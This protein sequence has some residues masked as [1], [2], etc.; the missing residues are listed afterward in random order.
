MIT[1]KIITVEEAEDMFGLGSELIED[2]SEIGKY[3]DAYI[4]TYADGD[5][6]TYIC[7]GFHYVNRIGYYLSQKPVLHNEY[8]AIIVSEYI[9]CEQCECKACRGTGIDGIDKECEDCRGTGAEESC[10]NCMGEGY[11][12]GWH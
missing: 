4:W 7:S 5:N 8:Y 10:A 6:G 3:D 1:P 9:E 2:L 12:T 11:R